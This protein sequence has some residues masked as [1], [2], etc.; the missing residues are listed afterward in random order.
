MDDAMKEALKE[1]LKDNL[2]VGNDVGYGRDYNG[3]RVEV[4]LMLDGIV[5]SSWSDSLPDNA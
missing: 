2:S 3:R 4:S 5:F 1:Y